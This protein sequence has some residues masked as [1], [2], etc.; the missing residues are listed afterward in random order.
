MVMFSL[1]LASTV[2]PEVASTIG[3]RS[4]FAA[5]ETAE[6]LSDQ[7]IVDVDFLNR[8]NKVVGWITST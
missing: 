4:P 6:D 2:T 3:A 7:I 1:Q 5:S 8:P